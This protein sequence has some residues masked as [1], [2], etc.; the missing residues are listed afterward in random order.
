M[1]KKPTIIPWIGK[2]YLAGPISDTTFEGA[3]SW[4]QYAQ[5]FLAKYGILG[6]SPMRGKDYFAQLMSED[7]TFNDRFDDKVQAYKDINEPMSTAQAIFHRDRWD[8]YRSDIILAHLI[9]F[10]KVSIGTVMELAWA[11]AYGKLVIAT[12][13]ERD[14][15]YHGMLLHTIGIMAGTLEEALHYT[16]AALGA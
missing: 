14:I 12:L 1:G 8:V 9:G 2:V 5:E 10:E 13:D 11:D 7:E 6:V 15:H 3:I 4:R 16:V